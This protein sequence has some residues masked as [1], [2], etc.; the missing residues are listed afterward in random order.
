MFQ[1]ILALAKSL[2]NAFANSSA[3]KKNTNT[4]LFL[5]FQDYN[6]YNIQFQVNQALFSL[7]L[8]IEMF[9]LGVVFMN[10]INI[11]LWIHFYIVC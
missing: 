1:T 8:L 9:K 11:A 7:N 6:T 4:E 3:T 10:A 5:H 2:K